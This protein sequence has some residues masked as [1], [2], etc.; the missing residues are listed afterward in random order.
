MFLD[1][2]ANSGSKTI[3]VDDSKRYFPLPQNEVELNKNI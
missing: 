3:N 2:I 1:K